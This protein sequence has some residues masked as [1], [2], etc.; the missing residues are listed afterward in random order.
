MADKKPK[1]IILSDSYSGQKLHDLTEPSYSIGRVEDQ[2]ICIP[3]TTVSSQHAELILLEDGNYMAKDLGSS[4]GTRVN[5]NRITEQV[6]QHS[7]ILQVGG[8]EILYH[9]DDDSLSTGQVAQ[10]G[11]NLE[12]TAGGLQIQQ[13]ENVSPLS[14]GG[15]NKDK[16]KAVTFA[17]YGFLALA[18]VIV[19]V[20]A[21]RLVLKLM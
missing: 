15:G 16:S 10:T 18:A 2:S 12:D 7:D 9:C 6:L 21:F 14:K 8:I 20:F 5:G 19:I 3:D 11:I 13:M 17:L 1:I 4:N